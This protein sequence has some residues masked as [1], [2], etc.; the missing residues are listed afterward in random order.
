MRYA[1]TIEA[2]EHSPGIVITDDIQG[3]TTHIETPSPV[4]PVP[5]DTDGFVFPVDAAVSLPVSAVRIPKFVNVTVRN[6]SGEVVAT[7]ANRTAHRI[8]EGRYVVEVE[9]LGVKVY[10]AVDGRLETSTDGTGRIVRT[11]ADT[12]GL[13]ARSRHE[14]PGATLTTTE[15][16]E[17]VM[18]AVSALGSA[19]KTTSPERSWPTLRGHPPLIE[20]GDRLEIPD[21]V[22]AAR[23]DPQVTIEVPPRFEFIYPVASLAFYLNA[24][25]VPAETPRIVAGRTHDLATPDVET[26]A[27]TALERIFLLDCVVRTEGF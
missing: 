25:L 23:E 17:D 10:L 15:A 24:D 20:Q 22:T 21:A 11:S 12:V 1:P 3:S 16:P 8:E 13:A 5:C 27:R 6:R 18:A 14:Y 19:L 9:S 7:A 26:A 4:D 2:T